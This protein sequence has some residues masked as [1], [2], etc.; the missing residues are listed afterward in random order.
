MRPLRL[1]L[2]LAVYV[3]LDF[4]NP[5]MPGAVSFGAEESVEARQAD[6]LRGADALG[7]LPLAPAGD[8]VVAIE[9][10]VTLTRMPASAPVP[11]WHVRSGRS[12]P[13][14]SGLVASSE[15]A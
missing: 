15:D 11:I 12:Y 9:P 3:A 4:S 5:L 2:L 14:R 7:P 10:A 6:R 1:A 13:T 8:R